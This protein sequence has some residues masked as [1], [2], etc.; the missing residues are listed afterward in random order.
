[1][2][3]KKKSNIV[4]KMLTVLCVFS[5]LIAAM[6]PVT[7]Q[8]FDKVAAKKKV[9]VTYKKLPD[10]VLAIYK[11]KNKTALKLK[12]TMRFLDGDNCDI[13]KD[14]QTSLCLGAKETATFFFQTPLDQFGKPINYSKYKGSFSVTKSKFKSKTKNIIVNSEVDVIESRFAAVNMGKDTLS[15]I[16]MTAVF[17]NEDGSLAGCSTKYLNCFTS[18]SIDQFSINYLNRGIHP[19]KVKVYINWA[20]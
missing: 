16:N 10:G 11:N 8:A 19:S 5:L 15:N 17:Y 13:A 12:A 7:T 14:T 6:Q 20:Y 1:M 2:Q 4:K 9:S 18:N 3:V